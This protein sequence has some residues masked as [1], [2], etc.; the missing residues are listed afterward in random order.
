MTD[1]EFD[2]LIE[3]DESL[4]L[5]LY[6][7]DQKQIAEQYLIDKSEQDSIMN[8]YN[9]E[10][11]KIND[12]IVLLT[13]AKKS[14]YLVKY[15]PCLD[16]VNKQINQTKKIL[17]KYFYNNKSIE[18]DDCYITKTDKTYVYVNN[19]DKLVDDLIYHGPKVVASAIKTF[20][21]EYIQKM[22]DL[23]LISE[24]LKK[25]TKPFFRVVKFKDI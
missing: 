13:K 5:E 9:A 18:L 8:Q 16:I 4:R 3:F 11:S 21:K 6:K 19:V 24:G 12:M 23:E 1:K 15:Q 25:S 7:Q 2:W 10:I 22:Y 20:D 14:L 17:S